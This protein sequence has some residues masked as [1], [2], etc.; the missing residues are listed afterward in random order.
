MK[1]EFVCERHP[2]RPIYAREMQVFKCL[3]MC[4][5][6]GR[7]CRWQPLHLVV[8]KYCIAPAKAKLL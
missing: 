3:N 5:Q 8:C 6:T 2:E 1:R 4:R 7:S